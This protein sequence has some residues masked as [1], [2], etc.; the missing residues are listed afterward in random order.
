MPRALWIP[1]TIMALLLVCVGVAIAA[2]PDADGYTYV[3]VN[4][5]SG[6]IKAREKGADCPKNYTASRLV[7]NQN[8][9]PVTTVYEVENHDSI[10]IGGPVQDVSATCHA[11]DTVISGGYSVGTGVSVLTTGGNPFPIG[12]GI[13][14][15]TAFITVFL[16]QSGAARTGFVYAMCSHTE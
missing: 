10:P 3:C 1:A 14:N 16:N 8:A 15:P 9:I 7:A 2:I 6:D 13:S 5:S 4:K 12:S 11:G